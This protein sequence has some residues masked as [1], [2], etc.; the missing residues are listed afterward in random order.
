MSEKYNTSKG[1][2]ISSVVKVSR[3]QEYKSVGN[4]L[5]SVLTGQPNAY[6]ST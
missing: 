2:K 1:E 4:P 3:H 6:S 5:F